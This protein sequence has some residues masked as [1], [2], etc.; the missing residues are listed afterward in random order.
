MNLAQRMIFFFER[1]ENILGNGEN[2]GY[3]Y[4]ILFSL[5]FQGRSSPRSLKLGI[6]YVVKA[7]LFHYEI[8]KSCFF[9]G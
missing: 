3:Q 6:L 8:N 9:I 7:E 2:A 1:V 5:C 4:F